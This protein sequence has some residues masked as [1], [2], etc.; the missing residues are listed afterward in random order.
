MLSRDLAQR[1]TGIKLSC[2]TEGKD[3]G[4][5]ASDYYFGPNAHPSIVVQAKRW[6]QRASYSKLEST[7][8]AL[9]NQLNSCDKL[10]SESLIFAVASGI[11]EAF[12][13]RLS[14]KAKS[15]GVPDFQLL[16]SV[17]FDQLLSDES[18]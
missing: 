2:Y 14:T 17:K 11:S 4:I 16:D 13:Q 7:M 15:L 5:D 10:P 1:L 6:I 9:I 18:N 12:Q 8:V 3:G